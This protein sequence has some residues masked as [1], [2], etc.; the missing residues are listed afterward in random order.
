[1]HFEGGKDEGRSEREG[2]GVEGRMVEQRRSVSLPEVEKKVTSRE[3]ELML[4][5]SSS[6]SIFSK[7][8]PTPVCEGLK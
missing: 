5:S 4:W 1:M 8:T 6:S 2:V 3:M 7:N